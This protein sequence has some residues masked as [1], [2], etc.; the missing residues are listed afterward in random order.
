MADS[1]WHGEQYARKNRF[2][3]RWYKLMM[4]L[5][6]IVVFCTT[7]AL[8]LPA[9]TLEQQCQIP[10]HQHTDDCYTRI[11]TVTH[12]E[13]ACHWD[14]QSVIIHQH[15]SYCYDENGTLQCDLPEVE[16]HT[17]SDGCYQ[18]PLISE[19]HTHS[20]SCD[21]LIQRELL[22][23]E[24]VHTES[25]YSSETNLICTE[26]VTEGH[27]HGEGCFDEEG[28]L[29]CELEATPGHS[30]GEGC[31]ETNTWRSCG[32]ESDHVHT[33]DC[34]LWETVRICNQEECDPVYGDPVL[35]CT[36]PEIIYHAHDGGCYD[37]EGVLVCEEPEVLSH[38][39]SASCWQT[40]EEPADT[41]TL[42]CGQE[43]GENHTHTAR[44]YGAWVLNCGL[45]EH[46]HTEECVP[47]P[48]YY[49]GMEPHTH[50]P[51]CYDDAGNLTCQLEEH[52]HTEECL[53]EIGFATLEGAFSVAE[54]E[55]VGDP[56]ALE[57]SYI[58]DAKLYYH[59]SGETTWKDVA[60][61]TEKIPGDASFKLEV[62][63][64]K[65]TVEALKSAGYTMTYELPKLLRDATVSAQ[66]TSGGEE[67]G[68]MSVENGVVKLIFD[69]NWVDKQTNTTLD[70]SF[71]V[72]AQANLSEIPNGGE[73]TI[74][75]GNV[76]IKI[77]F[78][79]DLIA[80]YGE[81]KI[82]KELG[83]L[84]ETEEGDF[85]NYTLTVTA[86]QDGCPDVTVTDSFTFKAL[87]NQYN[88]KKA[89]DY[90]EEYVLPDTE[91][92]SQENGVL[93]W[94]IG[95][96]NAGETKSLS[97]KVK[98]KSEYLGVGPKGLLTNTAKVYSGKHPRGESS[99][100]FE[101]K[102]DATLSK[103]AANYKPDGTGGG[104][105]QYTVWVK[106][107]DDNNYTLDN[108]TIWD[109]L[110]GTVTGGYKTDDS[111]LT[112]LSYDET[113]FSL[114]DGGVSGQN[115]ASGLTEA[116]APEDA[117]EIAVTGKNFKYNVGD[118]KPGQSKTLVYTV[119]VSPELFVTGN[120]DFEVKN[121]ATVLTDP[122]RSDG[123]N[124]RLENYN[125][126]KTITAK[127]WAEKLIGTATTKE[128]TISMTGT[129]CNQ[130]GQEITGETSFTIPVGSY[131]Y[132]V[133]VNEAG[134]WDVSSAVMKD[135]LS[136]QYM[137]YVG[138]VRVDA[139][140]TDKSNPVKTVWV[141]ID[142]ERNFSFT[143]ETIG[144]TDKTCSYVLNYYAVPDDLKEVST[145][146]VANEFDLTGDVGINGKYYTLAGI[147]VQVSVTLQ[148]S[149]Y[150][151]AGKN[152]WYYDA[153]ANG[154]G[155][156][157]GTMYW[158]I[159]AQ[160]NLIPKDTAFK[161]S[162]AD[163]TSHTVGK[164][165]KAFIAPTVSDW[166]GYSSI[167]ALDNVGTAFTDYTSGEEDD[168]LVLTLTENVRP[169]DGNSLYFIVST[170]PTMV[171][172][173]NGK[174]QVY[175][176]ALSTRDPGENMDWVSCNPAV[177]YL[178]GGQSIRKTM[179]SV[180]QVTVTDTEVTI[181]YTEGD[182]K[183]QKDVLR[184]NGS[185]I[186]VAWFVYVNETGM[187]QGDYRIQEQIPDGMRVVY[188]QRFQHRQSIEPT[189]G[190]ITDLDGWTEHR[191]N[192]TEDLNPTEAIYYT[193]GQQVIW[194][195]KNLQPQPGKEGDKFTN[196]L[197]VCK[198]TD[199]EV[200]LG[201]ET[202]RYTNTV[203]LSNAN[204]EEIGTGS[205]DV[206]LSYPKL[207]KKG[208]YDPQT[209]GGVYPFQIQ[210]NE[211]GTDLVQGSDE[212]RLID[213]MC[214]FLILDPSS[215]RVVKTGTEDAVPFTSS[216]DGQK[217]TL[218]LPDNLPLTITY[219]ATINAV[220]GQTIAIENN[221]Y[222]E[223]YAT[224]SGSG[225]KNEGFTYAA[226]ATVGSTVNPTVTVR[227]LDQY[228]TTQAL[229]DATFELVEGTVD[230]N[231][232]FTVKENGLKLTGTTNEKGELTFGEG[233]DKLSYNTVYC[234]TETNAPAGYVLDN[235]P[236]YFMVGKEVDGKYPELPAGVTGWY[237]SPT[238]TY[239]AYNH[240]GEI[241]V[242]KK[243]AN[244]D[245]TGIGT[246]SGS[247]T[248][249]LFDSENPTGE[250]LK[251]ATFAYANGK[252]VTEAVFKDV[253]LNKQFY[254]YELDDS[255]NPI[256]AGESG[257]VS[258]IPFV[259]SYQDNEVNVTANS[260][261]GTVT[262]TNRI[263]YPELPHTGG[264]GSEVYTGAGA[265]LIAAGLWLMYNQR[266]RR[267]EG[268]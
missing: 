156:S 43:E 133:K 98:L 184:G 261:M 73:T 109:A 266:K 101:P 173:G 56:L 16:E 225:V 11:T 161:D 120:A 224:T 181:S 139:Y 168:S 63:F 72:E 186:Y 214:D 249:G 210:I 182:T 175:K 62:Q 7:Y 82:E 28:N 129:I 247:Y 265:A 201:G 67:V 64:H 97:Y 83:D 136:N 223:G 257:T 92:V 88:G 36:E 207:S 142:G 155:H 103:V 172:E 202:K 145:V 217:L 102:A 32:V 12:Q 160:G 252:V 138:Y 131:K 164:V 87:Q 74:K 15:D 256:H 54:D 85:L 41:E 14:G 44:C 189:F 227:K 233:D 33:D 206:T 234:L 260:P 204:G 66:I 5:A 250:P 226:G 203:T 20:D 137:H 60:E 166:S 78:E 55:A 112:H 219:N 52:V 18:R 6:S 42:T 68:T 259:V 51:E 119:K 116:T 146:I 79:S 154:E 230:E 122:K 59:K 197:V 241:T 124:E 1:A 118:L 134:D 152:F 46:S 183:L 128:Q 163:G 195:V 191:K 95:N 65:V 140:Q 90:I 91:N 39:H 216:V 61:E 268:S 220:P 40:V 185:G 215:I 235:T 47:E 221:A 165:E 254:I 153:T 192:Y 89:E 170:Y 232:T 255:G 212:I 242:E 236:H 218:T 244:V 31:Y 187:L 177:T 100:T 127:T 106:A 262:V 111:I 84:E 22:C 149:N 198:V 2:Q 4:V 208:T 35:T 81:V 267:R 157:H 179:D 245:G 246:L 25:C 75:V 147:K 77:D 264:A 239:T 114:Y 251:R 105:I 205:A 150:F 121:R 49:C 248:F 238:Y 117:L 229:K 190:E 19:G 159:Q 57:G 26:P 144:L 125:C 162:I 30:H 231:G 38:Q 200:L 258:G 69:Q 50:L 9:I 263:N 21:T 176:N 53:V 132:T 80:Q 24:H 130:N 243:F 104:T 178:V 237:A 86:G 213:E 110:D 58:K 135:T 240:K 107:L 71:Y 34:Y 228:Q 222:W 151:Q 180:S 158:V 141:K 115:G 13:F 17:H 194:E 211:L 48:V 37:E 76:E 8:I 45:E 96:M 113:N 108:V 123:G 196:F 23:Q 148:G 199:P 209:N 99:A 93:T 94:A 126:G 29:I 193:K 169:G 70:G 167:G 174:S 3:R 143:P 27:F 171:P 10:E 253:E 188:V